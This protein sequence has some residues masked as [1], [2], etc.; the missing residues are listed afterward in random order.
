[1]RRAENAK[2]IDIN[3]VS[4]AHASGVSC[5][6]IA[7]D[8][9]E[10]IERAVGSVK[11]LVNE[12]IVVDTGSTDGTS[13]AARRAG[14]RV[15][16]FPWRGDFSAARNFALERA[17]E[18]WILVLD[19][20]ET[21][22]SADRG[23]IRR[24]LSMR[25]ADAFAFEQRT[26][27]NEPT[28]I[29]WKP[30]RRNAAAAR[31]ARGF[32]ACRQVRLFKRGERIAY[33]GR[34][35]EDIEPALQECGARVVDAGIAIHHYGRLEPCERVYRTTLAYRS[36]PEEMPALHRGNVRY[37]FETAVQLFVLGRLPEAR[38]LITRCLAVTPACWQFQNLRGLMDLRRGMTGDAIDWFR[39]ALHLQDDAPELYCNLAA[40]YMEHGSPERALGCVRRGISR[41]GADARLLE[42]AAVASRAAG[43]IDGAE[44]YIGEALS[45]D[46][47]RA[48]ALV[49]RAEILEARGDTD[50]A[51]RVLETVRFIAEVPL[52]AYLR[53]LHLCVRVGAI[54]HARR[55]VERAVAAYPGN[56]T[57]RTLQAK[58]FELDDDDAG[59][60]VV[61]RQPSHEQF[62]ANLASANRLPSESTC[63]SSPRPFG[64][65]RRRPVGAPSSL[66]PV[67]RPVR[68]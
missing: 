23:A 18:S 42:R 34:I 53:S 46:P 16:D 28:S 17:R 58:I 61:R 8:E 68:K 25:G 20:D 47:H 39:R 54:A 2:V 41:A 44:E 33:R 51:L 29:G 31:G 30:V 62:R 32:C 66:A 12:V 7:A 14:A 19:A 24:L 5:C 26:Y 4:D 60:R 67:R 40:A 36:S 38:E 48:G 55:F 56:D 64:D 65:S 27:C 13:A 10:R 59:A 63:V 22:A 15:V 57:L 52:G 6:I 49:S 3:S 50:G 9:E 11:D 43:D 21:I 35:F 1:M 45:A 37:A